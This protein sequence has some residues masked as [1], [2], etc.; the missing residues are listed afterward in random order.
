MAELR[1]LPKVLL[2]VPAFDLMLLPET[3][4]QWVEDV[5]T[6]MQCP[7]DFVAVTAMIG[8]RMLIGRKIA[9][10]PKRL[11]NWTEIANP[12]ASVWDRPA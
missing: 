8:A 12:W 2:P 7:I 11:D 3:F 1:D 5:G 9:V 4:R 6:R 10:R